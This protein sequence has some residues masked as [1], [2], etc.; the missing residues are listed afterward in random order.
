MIGLLKLA[1][2]RAEYQPIV[3]TR[4]KE[5]KSIMRLKEFAVKT[6]T[7][8]LPIMAFSGGKDSLVAYMM[9]IESEI[10]FKAIYSPTSV[11]PPELIYYIKKTF[12]PWAKEN[13]YPEVIFEKYNTWK[14]GPLKG[15]MKTMWTLIGNRAI[16]P[17]RLAR[18]CCDELKER[19]GEKG[20]V[21]I[22]GVRW[23]ESKN[24]SKRKMC[25]W[26]K[27][28]LQVRPIVDWSEVEVWSYIL[29][30]K[31]PYCKLYDEGWDR[32]GC[33]GCPL[34]SNQKRELQAY[35]KYRENYIR[36]FNHMVEYR[37]SKDMRCD[38]WS[39][40]EEIMK[41]WIGDCNKK[42]VEIDGQCSMF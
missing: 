35:P 28:K 33:I 31:I 24:R 37:R 27:E 20:D 25:N 1:K 18:Y 14:S 6:P 41:W 9:C 3:D 23:A 5:N 32:L 34:S 21:I 8:R 39:N 10:K 13:N 38:G 22:T 17:T 30:N 2:R 29:K 26:Y 7:G 11:D 15:K 12:N 40:G 19:T 36:A 4:E 42:R 16:P